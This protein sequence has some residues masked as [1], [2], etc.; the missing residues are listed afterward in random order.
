MG[1]TQDFP[2][3]IEDITELLRLRIRRR[4]ADGACRTVM[5]DTSHTL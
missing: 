1:Q 4:C 5:R 2:F 3:D